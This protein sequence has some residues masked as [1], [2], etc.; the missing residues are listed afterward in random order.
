VATTPTTTRA[1]TGTELRAAREAKGL[2]LAEAG[3]L[4]GIDR[5]KVMGHS[6]IGVTQRVYV[7]LYG[8][9]QAEEQ[10]RQ[11]MSGP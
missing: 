6:D 1:P 10:F 11:A 2:T 3:D 8:R 4:A 7:H 9:E 5:S